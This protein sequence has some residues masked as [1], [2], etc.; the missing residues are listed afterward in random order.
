AS[1]RPEGL[2]AP[3]TNAPRSLGRNRPRTT[4]ST[5]RLGPA[6]ASPIPEA[7]QR[8]PQTA[9]RPRG[10]AARRPTAPAPPRGPAARPPRPARRRLRVGPRLEVEMGEV[11]VVVDAAALDRVEVSGERE[12]VPRPRLLRRARAEVDV[13]ERLVELR[14]RRP[15]GD[16]PVQ[17]ER[18]VEPTPP[19]AEHRPVLVDEPV[20]RVRALGPVVVLLRVRVA[21][22]GEV[23]LA[24]L[25]LDP[26]VRAELL[27]RQLVH[28][29]R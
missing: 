18:L 25:E 6:R 22:G 5:P 29:L 1:P 10:P 15:G 7:A 11:V 12:V 23:E 8:P 26:A 4:R 9:R 2:S 21:A 19:R 14:P 17:R 13:A 3:R 16:A 24:A 20:A 28:R 27:R